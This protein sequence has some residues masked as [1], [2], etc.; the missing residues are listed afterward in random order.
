MT[1]DSRLRR[2]R[3]MSWRPRGVC[4]ITCASTADGKVELAGHDGRGWRMKAS[5]RCW[6]KVVRTWRARCLKQDLVDQGAPVFC[7]VK[8]WRRAGWRRWPGCRWIR[9]A[10]QQNSGIWQ[11]MKS[12]VRIGWQHTPACDKHRCHVHRHH[13]RHRH[14]RGH[15]AGRATP[16]LPLRAAMRRRALRLGP[17]LPAPAAA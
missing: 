16:A 1:T 3:V 7:A 13:H 9:C 2:K 11:K 12:W 6:L 14:H 10:P 8:A 15:R 17:R 5:A 4:V